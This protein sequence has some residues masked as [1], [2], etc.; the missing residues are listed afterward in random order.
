[1]SIKGTK[2]STETQ[3]GPGSEDLHAPP[4]LPD[5]GWTWKPKSGRP[6]VTSPL[7]THPLLPTAGRPSRFSSPACSPPV[8]IVPEKRRFSSATFQAAS[9]TSEVILCIFERKE[10]RRAD[11]QKVVPDPTCDHGRPLP[12][13][14]HVCQS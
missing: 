13:S 7:A 14:H 10:E 4:A 3:G 11:R 9:T 6:A 1:M 2:T 8:D 12:H 5:D